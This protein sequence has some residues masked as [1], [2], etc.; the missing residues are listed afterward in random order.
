MT[1]TTN[2]E[3]EYMRLVL[4]QLQAEKERAAKAAKAKK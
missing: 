2:Y 4:Q 3:R 1:R